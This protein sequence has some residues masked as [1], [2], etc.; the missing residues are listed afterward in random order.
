M[1]F[2]LNIKE[3]YFK[4]LLYYQYIYKY[5]YLDLKICNVTI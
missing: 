1:I 3:I 5:L 2:L 4:T